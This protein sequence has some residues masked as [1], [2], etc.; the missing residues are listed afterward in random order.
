[1]WR[2]LYSSI[3]VACAANDAQVSNELTNTGLNTTAKQSLLETINLTK[4]QRKYWH[5]EKK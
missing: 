2:R 4:K 5:K 1:M 3:I